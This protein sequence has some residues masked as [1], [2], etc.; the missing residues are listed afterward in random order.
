MEGAGRQKT[1]SS[2]VAGTMERFQL[3]QQEP[4]QIFLNH[5]KPEL[6]WGAK[7]QPAEPDISEYSSNS[8]A[9]YYFMENSAIDS[10][11]KRYSTN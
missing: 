2:L 3:L 6:T 8:M 1:R 10:C 5:V 9:V 4:N 11:M 7:S